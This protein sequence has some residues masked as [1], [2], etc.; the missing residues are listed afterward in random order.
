MTATA[1]RV[2]APERVEKQ[3]SSPETASPQFDS[4]TLLASHKDIEKP[5]DTANLHDV[6]IAGLDKKRE[7]APG[8]EKPKA[9]APA[10]AAEKTQPAKA[11]TDAE[12]PLL[13]TQHT[14]VAGE[15]MEQIARQK[16]GKDASADEIK[17]YS[18]ATLDANKISADNPN[19][20]TKL[21]LPG[22]KPD[23]EFFYTNPDNPNDHIT[24]QKDGTLDG[25]NDLDGT[26]Y[27]QKYLDGYGSYEQDHHGPKDS[28]NYKETYISKEQYT[29]RETTDK[30]GTIHGVGS[31]GSTKVTDKDGNWKAEFSASNAKKD[32]SYDK[33]SDVM[34]V[35]NRDGSTITTY[36]KDKST[37]VV[38]R[39]G[40][41]TVDHADGTETVEKKNADGQETFSKK[42]SA[43]D[44]SYTLDSD[45]PKAADN[46]H[47]TYDAKSGK[48][49]RTEGKGTPE[50]K[51]TTHSPD[52]TIRVE[53]KDGDNY[54]RNPDGSEHH[55]GNKTFDKPPYDYKHDAAMNQSRTELEQSMKDHIPQKQQ[56]D[57]KKDMADFEARAHKE[58]LPPDEITK[59]YDQMS[60]L[61]NAKDSESVVPAANRALLAEQLIHQTA[62][63]SETYQ[64]EHNTCNVTTIAKETLAKNPSKMAEMATST[65]LKGEWTAADGKVIKIDKESLTPGAEE[66]RVKTKDGDRSYA[67]QVLDLTLANDGLQ[68]RTPPESYAQRTPDRA[69]PGDTGERSLDASG[70]VVQAKQPVNDKWITTPTNNPGLTDHELKALS[71]E[72]NGDNSHLIAP[73]SSES[74]IERVESAQQLGQK[75]KQYKDQNQFPI[76]LAVDDN[77]A[78]IRDKND[79][80]PAYGGHVVNVEDYDAKNGKVKIS[81]QWGAK[82]N[83]WVSLKDL[84]ANSSGEI[85][86][87]RDGVDADF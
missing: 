36:G 30:D 42:V 4:H 32:A 57:F 67:T 86:S 3:G 60:K 27:H 10:D 73:K 72:F 17:R 50:E 45:G 29:F 24:V 12:V 70:N 84:Y 48:T 66:S 63:P 69:I 20:G 2:T 74:G 46:F 80:R 56:A 62:H 75:L 55:W 82:Y 6:H 19:P 26:S 21:T 9:K 43:K 33:N 65:A 77:H 38:D 78:P 54:Q 31:D 15:T 81:N 1:D 11:K 7:D 47:E 64:G 58:H 23:G 61:L 85:A 53:A 71:T 13:E 37:V 51:T 40:T 8:A 52:G 41:R 34:T 49:V 28:D 68:R 79:E 76:S 87:S 83:R 59:T 44:G 18:D 22:R 25:K 5:K 16:L 14:V 35:H 39:D